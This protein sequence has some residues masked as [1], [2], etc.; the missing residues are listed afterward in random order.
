MNRPQFILRWWVWAT[1]WIRN[2]LQLLI[3]EFGSWSW[4]HLIHDWLLWFTH[5]HFDS[6][7][8]VS[9]LNFWLI[10]LIEEQR[11]DIAIVIHSLVHLWLLKNSWP[12]CFWHFKNTV[13]G[14]IWD[15]V[16]HTWLSLVMKES[17]W[18]K[19]GVCFIIKRN[20]WLVW[21]IFNIKYST[22][23]TVLQI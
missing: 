15:L 14:D 1:E 5:L 12:G 17:H 13:V 20:L 16:L 9:G 2:C 19:E 8:S 18:S 10:P 11:C 7:V 22:D 21:Y 3:Y 23:V 6:V 4:N